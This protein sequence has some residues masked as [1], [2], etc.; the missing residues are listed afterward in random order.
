MW[1][2]TVWM[3]LVDQG[4]PG[5]PGPE[6]AEGKPGT[7]VPILYHISIPS[8]ARAMFVSLSRL[9]HFDSSNSLFG[10]FIAIYQLSIHLGFS[11]VLFVCF[12]VWKWGLVH[13][14]TLSC[15]SSSDLS[16]F[17]RQYVCEHS[18][19]WPLGANSMEWQTKWVLRGK[20]PQTVKTQSQVEPGLLL[21]CVCNTASR[22]QEALSAQRSGWW[23]WCIL[24]VSDSQD[25]RCRA[26]NT[27]HF[28]LFIF[29][30]LKHADVS[31]AIDWGPFPPTQF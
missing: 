6:G 7:Q 18:V 2:V 8:P 17:L 15:S 26:S 11:P 31:L 9:L 28:L 10:I 19:F 23:V 4:L 14:E 24:S 29:Q 21:Q 20:C 12:R 16:L 13:K 27:E 25:H 30:I 5:P 1:I 3:C 22:Q